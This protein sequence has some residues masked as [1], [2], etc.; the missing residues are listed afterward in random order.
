M[1]SGCGS[2]ASDTED[3]GS[4]LSAVEADADT[5]DGDSEE[6]TTAE[7]TESAEDTGEYELSE[8]DR[9][10]L[11]AIGDDLHVVDEAD[12]ASVVSGLTSENVGQVYQLTGYYVVA[13]AD[14]GEE[15]PFLSDGVGEEMT[16]GIE[17]TYLTVSP[18]VGA[19]YTIY[20]IVGEQEHEDHTDIVLE[21][22][23]IESYSGD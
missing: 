7:T 14:D 11:E 8:D 21:V 22:I 3:A 18:T 5:Q 20:G 6:G 12:F 4:E 19:K 1:L 13:E 15:A 2:G 16:T 23:T 17:L 9:E 10:T